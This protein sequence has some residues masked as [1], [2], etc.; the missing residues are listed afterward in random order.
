MGNKTN[1]VLATFP[2]WHT[3]DR[4]VFSCCWQN[5]PIQINHRMNGRSKLSGNAFISFRQL[6]HVIATTVQRSVSIVHMYEINRQEHIASQCPFNCFQT[7]WGCWLIH[8]SSTHIS[9][10][11]YTY[12]YIRLSTTYTH[13]STTYICLVQL[14][15]A[16]A[17][18]FL[19]PR[20]SVLWGWI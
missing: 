13:L 11:T 16:I 3:L 15:K 8:F 14:R 10:D 18:W 9:T 20:S 7:S 12:T 4:T 2:A 19:V 5:T 1:S 17:A 6:A